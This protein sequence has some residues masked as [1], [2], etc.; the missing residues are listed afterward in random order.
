MWGISFLSLAATGIMLK[1]IPSDAKI[2]M[3]FDSSGNVNRWG[4]R[5]ELFLLPAMILIFS[6]VFHLV[7]KRYEKKAELA[8]EEKDREGHL[9]NAK[10]LGICGFAATVFFTI[11]Q[12][13]IFYIAYTGAK[14]GSSTSAVDLGSFTTVMIGILFI[15][16]GNIMPK[17][18]VNGTIGVRC[19]WSMYNDNTWRKTNHFGG[20]VFIIVGIL[21]IITAAVFSDSFGATMIMIF[22][23]VAG[24]V[25][26]IVYAYKVYR[27]EKESEGM[28]GESR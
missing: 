4:S 21:T 15:V 3:H 27:E 24:S 23:L 2:P 1:L 25:I 8:T 20:I 17:T 19:V 14:S 12:G 10:T 9:S 13:V 26:T 18:R 5:Y 16:L 7:I 6:L 22:Y 28:G 11:L